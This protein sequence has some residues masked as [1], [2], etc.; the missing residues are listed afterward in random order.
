M[1]EAANTPGSGAAGPPADSAA[2]RGTAQIGP[3]TTTERVDALDVVRGF[4]ILG[5]LL[6]N[7]LLFAGPSDLRPGG[8]EGADLVLRGLVGV[9]AET[10]FI[11]AFAMLF[12]L[13]LAYQVA[14][15]DDRERPGLP[16]VARRLAVLAVIGG[17]HAVLIWSGDILLPYVVLGLILLP[18]LRRQPRTCVIWAA[19]L[20]VGLALFMLAGGGLFAL[21]KAVGGPEMAEV[22]DAE[23]AELAA[24][25]DAAEEV[26]TDGSYLDQVTFRATQ[27]LPLIWGSIVFVLPMLVA[28][29]LLG[30]AIVRSGMLADLASRRPL[31]RRWTIIGLAVGLPMNAV[32]GWLIS[33]DATATTPSSILGWGLLVSGGPVLALGYA[34][35]VARGAL[36]RPDAA[37]W[38]WLGNVGRTALSN[39]LLQSVLA[40]AV[41]Y[42]LGLYG[43]LPLTVAFLAV[44][45]IWAVNL[46]ASAWWTARFRFGPVEWLWRLG[47]YGT[48]PPL[49]RG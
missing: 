25:T 11:T 13:G 43:Q 26:Y 37:V 41:F 17:V 47:T 29:G 21:G 38:R 8:Y 44:P 23:V 35:M 6:V 31:L 46:L 34:S 12:G 22:I 42:G 36:A 33:G 48:V 30:V 20:L 15:A 4:A 19:A 2:A 9:F 18:F 32:A 28:M 16:L 3:I 7:I 1:G 24:F 27:E 10:K 14:R 49:R 39:Y 5:I 45:A 40:T